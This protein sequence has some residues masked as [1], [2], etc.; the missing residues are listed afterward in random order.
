MFVDVPKAFKSYSE[1]N[2]LDLLTELPG[3]EFDSEIDDILYF[4]IRYPETMIYILTSLLGDYTYDKNC[5]YH[6]KDGTVAKFIKAHKW[7]EFK[8]YKKVFVRIYI[9]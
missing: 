8:R 9:D 4:R 3:C 5:T 6:Y 7:Y 2:C 1:L